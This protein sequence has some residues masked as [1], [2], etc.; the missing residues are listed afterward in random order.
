MQEEKNTQTN[1]NQ[2]ID[3]NKFYRYSLVC[4]YTKFPELTNYLQIILE[5]NNFK[6]HSFKNKVGKQENLI[7]LLSY[8]NSENLLNQ[9]QVSK[10]RK[11]QI[12]KK[13]ENLNLTKENEKEEKNESHIDQRIL[14]NEKKG[15]FFKNFKNQYYPDENY[16]TN[17]SHIFSNKKKSD[18]KNKN[19]NEENWGHGLFIEAEM[20][21][22]ESKLLKEIKINKEDFLNLCKENE[23]LNKKIDNIEKYLE[24]EE[25]LI[26]IFEFFKIIIDQTPLH[27]S[28][29]RQEILKETLFSWRCPY[30]KIRCYFGDSIAIYYAWFYHY[31]RWLAIPGIFALLTIVFN[32]FFPFL[33]K[34]SLTVYALFL[35][36]WSQIFLIYWERKCSEISIEW[37]NYTDE[38]EIDNTRRKFKGEWRRSPVTG[39]YEKYYPQK[40]RILKYIISAL[41]SLPIIFLSVFVNIIFMNLSAS[42]EREHGS[43]FEIPYLTNLT[44]KDQIFDK[45]TYI[46]TIINLLWGICLSKINSVYEIICFKTTNWENHKVNSTFNNSLIFKRFTFEFFNQFLSPFYFGFVIFNMNG[47]RTYMVFYFIFY[48]IFLFILIF[49]LVKSLYFKSNIKIN[50][51]ISSSLFYNVNNRKSKNK[52]K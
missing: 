13:P 23:K 40:Q 28:D 43:Y 18:E 35:S 8:N 46:N 15:I 26:E 14:E 11:K 37:D 20:L 4:N 24:T 47:L 32:L 34:L 33:S 7:I 17:Y 25:H 39:K 12:N 6:I 31:T 2:N 3:T 9:A 50:R 30:R 5:Q 22:L 10:M 16:E 42:I 41:A 52:L 1:S 44:L 27:I 19:E 48:F 29:F 38:Y 21:Y 36:L 45:D 49:I 51:R